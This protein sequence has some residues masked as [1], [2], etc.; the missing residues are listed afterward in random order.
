ME[1][2]NR[3]TGALISEG[4][5]RRLNPNTSFPPVLTDELIDEFGYDRVLEGTQPAVTPPYEYV[6][7]DGV[8]QIE[9]AWY[10]NYVI[11]PVFQEYI[12]ENGVTHSASE[13]YEAYCFEKDTE[14]GAAIRSDRNQRL[15]ACDWTQLLDSPFD[16]SIKTAWA[17]YREEL[18]NIPEQSGFPWQVQWPT[19]PG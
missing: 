18:R 13:Q 19:K 6:Q 16:P 1:L 9:G 4:D 3:T 5:L 7:R 14:Q 2:R 8:V 12:D 15:S 10:T 11:G 17:L